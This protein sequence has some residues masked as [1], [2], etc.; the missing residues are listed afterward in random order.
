[1]NPEHLGIAC[2]NPNILR[3]QVLISEVSM[4]S[5]PMH[6]DLYETGAITPN[7][8][9][10]RMTQGNVQE[11]LATDSTPVNG[12]IEVIR[13]SENLRQHV[14]EHGQRLQ[15]TVCDP[16]QLTTT[17]NTANHNL[18]P[19]LHID[20]K[21]NRPLETRAQS[22]RRIGLNVGPGARFLLIGSVS[23]FDIA[24]HSGW[25]QDYTPTTADVREYASRSHIGEMPPLR[26]LWL[27][28]KPGMAYIAPTE[29]IIHDGSTSGN[30]LGSTIYFWIG[31]PEKR[32]ELGTIW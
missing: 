10:H 12:L 5:P 16:R 11:F 21:E 9:L 14:I 27:L 8:R 7:P 3:E 1:M 26:C 2:N 4:M 18:R 23:I 24:D 30:R 22:Q 31:A 17:E 28:L 32:G 6:P 13:I 25:S 20:S 19:G 29:N 15:P